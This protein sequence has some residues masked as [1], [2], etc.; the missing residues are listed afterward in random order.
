MNHKSLLL[1]GAAL[2]LAAL[3]ATAQDLPDLQGRVI[4]AVTEN[5]YYP[6]NFADPKSGNGIGLE[7][8]LINEIGYPAAG[9]A[10][11]IER[12]PASPS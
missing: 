3:P 2:V 1:A 11:I 6:L 5:A 8:D 10:D 9:L 4:H 12:L 7:Y